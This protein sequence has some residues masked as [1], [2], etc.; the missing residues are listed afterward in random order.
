MHTVLC[1]VTSTL[2][3]DIGLVASSSRRSHRANAAPKQYDAKGVS[4]AAPLPFSFL[5]VRITCE[6][7]RMVVPE[8][9]WGTNAPRRS[10]P[11]LSS[12]RELRMA[13]GL[14]L[15]L[16]SHQKIHR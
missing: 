11:D 10:D 7:L 12:R 2:S 13:F 3:S 1:V 14:P 9:G 4:A 15:C 6:T 5:K 16:V 8:D